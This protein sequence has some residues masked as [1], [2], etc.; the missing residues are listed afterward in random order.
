MKQI[1]LAVFILGV[2]AATF[3]RTLDLASRLAQT[4]D[5][6]QGFVAGDAVVRGNILLSGWHF[7]F[8]DYYLTDT[9]P[10]AAFEL[11]AGPHPFFL[12]LE[13]ALVYSLFVCVALVLSVRRGQPLAR[14]LQAIAAPALVLAA[15]AWIGIW[16]PLLMSDMHFATVL[17][18]V[19]GLWLCAIVAQSERRNDLVFASQCAALLLL[20]SAAIASDPFSLVFAFGPALAVLAIDPALGASNSGGRLALLLLAGGIVLGW[21]LPG[22]IAQTGGFTTERDVLT[23]PVPAHLLGRNLV[24]LA[25]SVLTLFGANPSATGFTAPAILLFVVHAVALALGLVAVARVAGSVFG[26]CRISILDRFLCAGIFAVLVAC[27]VSAQFAKGIA[28]ATLWTGGPTMR[29][30]MPVFLFAGVLAGRKA[31]S[32]LAAIKSLRMRATV[33]WVL[34]GFALLSVVA[35]AFDLPNS[36][37]RW[38]SNNPP[39]LAARWLKS[40]GLIQGVGEYWSSNLVTAMSGDL[41]RV[42]SVVA[43][44]GRLAA[45]V[46]SSDAKWY[47]QPPQFAIWQD[48]N[49]SGLTYADVGATYTIC[50]MALVAGYRIAVLTTTTKCYEKNSRH[51]Y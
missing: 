49:P 5:S 20:I 1:T 48:G 19:L 16:N 7:P 6:V 46:W 38:I 50:E 18:A 30:V 3:L 22:L 43:D 42:R 25:T 24:A 2:T 21:V 31:P 23:G 45:Y 8:N 32:V 47:M 13:P 29:Y 4:S 27:T 37:P 10:Y 14:N 12:A 44:G 34:T 33:S 11:I 41:V 26:K 15:P 39:T 40:H 35:G 9:V 28:P 51:L 36:A 17:D